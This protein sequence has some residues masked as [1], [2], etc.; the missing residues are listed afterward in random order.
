MVWAILS[1]T[2]ELHEFVKL[3]VLFE[4]F[5][6]HQER[7][8]TVNFMEFLSMHYWGTDLNDDDD[9]RDMQLPF[10]KFDLNP[11]HVQFI[12]PVSVF[13]IKSAVVHIALT[14]PAYLPSYTPDP[15]PAS[16]FRPPCA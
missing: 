3:P 1:Q 10:K 4:H 12:P 16:T 9:S 2:T 6:E 7:D 11:V 13:K 5:A 8:A 14:Y 15:E